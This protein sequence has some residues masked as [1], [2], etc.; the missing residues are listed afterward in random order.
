M[1]EIK[2]SSQLNHT[3]INY[4]T[5]QVF[6]NEYQVVI[7]VNGEITI[8]KIL[9]WCLNYLLRLG[10]NPFGFRVSLSTFFG[11]LGIPKGAV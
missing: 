6:I 5:F 4:P 8:L 10:L 11:K 2:S 3:L 1:E 9:S 7:A